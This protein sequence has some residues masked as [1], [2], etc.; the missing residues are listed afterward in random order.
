MWV[1]YAEKIMK[2]AFLQKYICVIRPEVGFMR[3]SS[4]ICWGHSPDLLA[5]EKLCNNKEQQIRHYTDY[6][7]TL[8][9]FDDSC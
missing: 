3:F 2:N 7:I 5:D 1:R 6:T 9:D 8:T 4:G